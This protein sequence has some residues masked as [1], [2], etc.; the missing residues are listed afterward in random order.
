M[1]RKSSWLVRVLSIYSISPDFLTDTLNKQDKSRLLPTTD[2]PQT[3]VIDYSSPN[4]AKEMHVG[5]LRG[6][7]IGD[8][9][10]RSFEWMGHKLIRQNHFGDWGTQ[11]GMLITYMLEL[12]NP[13]T[14]LENLEIFYRDAKKRFD[15]DDD[16]A[17]RARD[18][19][20]K[21]QSGDSKW[22]AAMATVH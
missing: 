21:L 19:V 8:A 4:L 11:F 7:I 1:L 6:T 13:Q 22:P 14:R 9:I 15:E 16:F 3:I 2:S 12:E 10:A 17:K 20:V 18:N 5:H